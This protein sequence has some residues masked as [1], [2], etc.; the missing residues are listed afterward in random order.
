MFLVCVFFPRRI[1]SNDLR[2]NLSSTG[3]V[4]NVE[5]ILFRRNLLIHLHR[6]LSNGLSGY[7]APSEGFGSSSQDSWART[8]DEIIDICRRVRRHGQTLQKPK[9][10]EGNRL[11]ENETRMREIT[12][13][14]HARILKEKTEVRKLSEGHI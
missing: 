6:L 14:L 11:E 5:R 8:E 3:G 1:A 7:M 12:D 10:C 13:T 9:E 2:R 4:L